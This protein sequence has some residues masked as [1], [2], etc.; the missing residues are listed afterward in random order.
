MLCVA[1]GQDVR[2]AF[3]R[4]QSMEPKKKKKISRKDVAALSP[5]EL[6]VQTKEAVRGM[7][8][9]LS[10]YKWR[11][12]LGVLLGVL[13]GLFNIVILTGMQVVMTVVLKGQTAELGAM[14]LPFVGAV[15]IGQYLGLKDDMELTLVPV[16]LLCLTLPVLFLMRGMIGYLANYFVMWV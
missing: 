1:S 7:S 15:N 14:Q 11:F 5:G 3:D 12:L 8:R 6:W 13:S 16:I 10:P 4:A 9:Y 2:T